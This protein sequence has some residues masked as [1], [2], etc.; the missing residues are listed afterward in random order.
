MICLDYD[1]VLHFADRVQANTLAL[2]VNDQN[3]NT[4]TLKDTQ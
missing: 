2:S 1:N 3:P 4:V